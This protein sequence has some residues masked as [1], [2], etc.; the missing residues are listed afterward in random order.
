MFK[1]TAWIFK[2]LTLFD[3][4]FFKP[5]VMRGGGGKDHEGPSS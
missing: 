2:S 5:S 1:K 3:M 4:G